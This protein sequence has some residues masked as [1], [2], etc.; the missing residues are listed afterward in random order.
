[1]TMLGQFP[2]N[3]LLVLRAATPGGPRKVRAVACRNSR[4]T[5][6]GASFHRNLLIRGACDVGHQLLDGALKEIT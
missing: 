1:M 5:Q 3:T 6:Q 4:I 2:L